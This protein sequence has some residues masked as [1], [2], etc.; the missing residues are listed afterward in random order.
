MLIVFNFALLSLKLL[1]LWNKWIKL[2][3]EQNI[4][5]DIINV[6]TSTFASGETEI[7]PNQCNIASK[8]TEE[9]DKVPPVLFYPHYES[10]SKLLRTLQLGM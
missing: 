8:L 7:I 3:I 1:T 4:E 2:L 5:L 9:L 10:T 6:L